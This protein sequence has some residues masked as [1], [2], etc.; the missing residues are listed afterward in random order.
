MARCF[1]CLLTS[2]LLVVPSLA[3]E[4]IIVNLQETRPLEF[5]ARFYIDSLTDGVSESI[6]FQLVNPSNYPILLGKPSGTCGC[7]TVEVSGT[8]INPG[9]KVDGKLNVKVDA[10]RQAVW[11][12][13]LMFDRV[14][15]KN[16]S[17]DLEIVSDIYG[18]LA[19]RDSEFLV[20]LF[21]SRDRSVGA[22]K[23]V[24]KHLRFSITVPI[25]VNDLELTLIP[26]HPAVK[27]E[28]AEVDDTLGE[29]RLKI[30]PTKDTPGSIALVCRL[31]DTK[32]SK[33]AEIRGV[34][35]ERSAISVVPNL[36][37]V[38]RDDV[39]RLVAHA[40]VARHD[41]NED[42]EDKH[43]SI[44]QVNA[45]LLDSELDIEITRV[46]RA[47]SRVRVKIPVA[48]EDRLSEDR[49]AR[50]TWN[51]RWGKDRSVC[52]TKLSIDNRVLP[53]LRQM[54]LGQ[55]IDGNE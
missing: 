22:T 34:F 36:L 32:S 17:V 30:D 24:E 16:S 26:N 23:S 15:S 18:Q 38:S 13:R 20:Q 39:D 44:P 7:I 19:F 31:T 41:I 52:E 53:S 55:S 2:L 48:I 14:D 5:F 37:R 35:A 45:R 28:I 46:S 42:T 51:I 10:K 27:G 50:V 25:K 33:T 6:P 8:T 43:E 4:P 40:I 3:R 54:P 11:R 47:V 49:D 9:G 12:Q 21:N 1:S 29:V